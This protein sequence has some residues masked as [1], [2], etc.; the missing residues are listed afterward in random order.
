MRHDT[1]RHFSKRFAIFG[2]VLHFRGVRHN[3]TLFDTLSI[4]VLASFFA[5]TGQRSTPY[6]PVLI[7]ESDVHPYAPRKMAWLRFSAWG[8]PKN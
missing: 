2:F 6:S 3:L 5:S 4:E 7:F 1:I 8:E